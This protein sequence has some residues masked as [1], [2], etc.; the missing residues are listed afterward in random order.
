MVS[1]I[2]NALLSETGATKTWL[3]NKM[4][5][6]SP[7]INMTSDKLGSVARGKRKMSGDE[8]IALFMAARVNP[9]RFIPSLSDKRV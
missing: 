5:E 2:L 7:G 8:L 3:A 9:D 4:N 1:D 6:V